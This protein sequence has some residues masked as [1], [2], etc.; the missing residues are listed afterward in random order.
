MVYLKNGRILVPLLIHNGNG[1]HS[2]T[3]LISLTEGEEFNPYYY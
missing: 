3:L 2:Q 1:K